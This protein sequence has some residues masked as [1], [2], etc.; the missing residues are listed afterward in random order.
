VD[1]AQ[2]LP[3]TSFF[4]LHK[5]NFMKHLRITVEGK[6][7]D[8]EVEFLD[9]NTKSVSQKASSLKGVQSST[10]GTRATTVEKPAPSTKLAQ[11]GK[12]DI[13]SPLAAVV[14]SVDV[15][16][17]NVVEQGQKVITLEAMKMNT[18]VFASASGTVKEIQVSAGDA[19]EEGQPL[20]K[21]G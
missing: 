19:V 14:V 18:T 13:V 8:V 20:I 9:E 15:A 6:S 2:K 1:K 11:P 17:G 3:R 4:L 16:V 7:Y 10:S 5:L 21:L 12:N